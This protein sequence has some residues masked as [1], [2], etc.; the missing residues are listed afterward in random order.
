MKKM[1]LEERKKWYEDHLADLYL[2]TWHGMF[3]RQ[4]ELA[5]HGY[6]N[7][8]ISDDMNVKIKLDIELVEGMMNH[9]YYGSAVTEQTL[10]KQEWLGCDLSELH[11]EIKDNDYETLVYCLIKDGKILKKYYSVGYAEGVDPLDINHIVGEAKKMNADGIYNV[12]NHPFKIVAWPGCSDTRIAQKEELKALENGL[13]YNYGVV[14]CEDYWD[15]AQLDLTR[16]KIDELC[17]EKYRLERKKEEEMCQK[18]KRM[19]TK[20]ILEKIK[21]VAEKQ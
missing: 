17:K 21:E 12:H 5:K 3:D 18:E 13:A 10:S 9:Y 11:A 4:V 15:Y 6:I 2:R 14:S 1:S 7:L 19:S 16:D 20:D 8:A